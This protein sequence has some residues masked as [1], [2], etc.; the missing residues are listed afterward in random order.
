MTV[1][2]K[3]VGI[4]RNLH[5]DSYDDLLADVNTLAD[6]EVEA[7]G[8]WSLAQVCKHLAEALNGSIDGVPFRAPWAMRTFAKIFLKKKFLSATLP[9]GFKIPA[10]AKQ[11]F[12]PDE[13]VELD[14]QLQALRQAV[15]RVKTESKRAIHPFFDELSREDWDRFNLRHAELHL[16]FIRPATP[17]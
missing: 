8:N 5:F 6:G 15:D 11:R 16:S 2:T 1:D 4:R 7:V 13:S 14:A 9:A 10:P 3:K 17:S 12:Q